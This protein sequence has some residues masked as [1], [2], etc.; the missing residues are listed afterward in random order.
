MSK[1]TP[2]VVF[3]LGAE[4]GR[5]ILGLLDGGGLTIEEVHR[6]AN[7]PVRLNRTLYWNTPGLFQEMIAGLRAA[8]AKTV[9][10]IKAIG[11]DTW[12]VDFGILDEHGRLAGLPV[13]YRD[14]R[15]QG[16]M[17]R[18]FER[19]PREEIYDRTGIQFLPF[20]TI[21]QLMAMQQENSPQL[22]HG[23]RLL[24]MSDLLNYFFSGVQVNEYS[25]ASTTQLCD[26][27]RRSWDMRLIQKLNLPERLFGDVVEPGTVLGPT[28]ADVAAEAGLANANTQIVASLGHDTAAAVAAVPNQGEDSCFISSGTWSL[29]GAV[30]PRPC[31]SEQARQHGF[32]N[33]GGI[34]G[35]V[36]FLRN[37][38]GLWLVQQSK[39]QFARDG[40]SYT[41][42][43]LTKLAAEA[44]ALRSLIDPD[45]PEF[46]TPGNSV[47]RIAEQCRR[48]GQ[49]IPRT[50]GEVIR[51]ILE[52]L[53]MRY[54]RTLES[55]QE[56]LGRTFSSIQIVGGGSQ[57]QLLNQLTADCTGLPVI[58][59]PA[60]ATAIGNMMA[61]AVAVGAIPSHEQSRE[62]VARSFATR[63]YT[64]SNGRAWGEGYA[65]FLNILRG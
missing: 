37:I 4:S 57:N 14:A 27:R 42:E 62:I 41:Y 10:E 12:G 23:A 6:F 61:V 26:P 3:D 21:Y 25:N 31:L 28:L 43:Q 65:D 33:E 18:A 24:L 53:A 32:T 54:R 59:G 22:R 40:F 49:P 48:N 64:P 58:A 5:A 7:R 35:S 38:A 29:M 50:H 60:E 34:S 20:N 44:E 63:T 55:L 13:H 16:M 45:D 56:V 36:R 19:V 8:S 9:G 1:P 30:I 11:I 52:S 15:T 17:E 47:E 39:A 2:L 51:C 46:L